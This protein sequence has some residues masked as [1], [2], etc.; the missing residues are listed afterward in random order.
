MAHV[1]SQ[2]PA[3]EDTTRGKAA[4]PVLALGWSLSLSFALS[5]V[6]CVLGFYVLPSLPIAHGALSIPLPGFVLGSFPRFLLGLVES[7]A[8][9]WYIALIFGPLYNYF[10]DRFR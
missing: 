5:F 10:A 1:A 2:S 7:F 4:I 9:G 6:L 3:R 8:W